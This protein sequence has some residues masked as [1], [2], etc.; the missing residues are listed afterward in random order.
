MSEEKTD[1]HYVTPKDLPVCCPPKE[2]AVWDQHPRVYLPIGDT[3]SVTCPYC[4]A[5]YI[6]NPNP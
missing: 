4:S 2:T 3:G 5:K 1:V 6:L